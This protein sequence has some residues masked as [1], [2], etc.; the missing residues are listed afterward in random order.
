[1]SKHPC[2]PECTPSKKART[3]VDYAVFDWPVESYVD[4]LDDGEVQ[5]VA[6]RQ[7]VTFNEPARAL[8][9]GDPE[10]EEMAELLDEMRE[11]VGEILPVGEWVR[12]FKPYKQVDIA[13]AAMAELLEGM[14]SASDPAADPYPVAR[15]LLPPG[16]GL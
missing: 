13:L 3:D 10:L 6:V 15:S 11:L 7:T 14:P 2:A 9:P 5:C 4:A 12:P 8:S 16:W 1:M